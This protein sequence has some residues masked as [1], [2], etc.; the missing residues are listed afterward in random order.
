MSDNVMS[1]GFNGVDSDMSMLTIDE[2]NKR[3]RV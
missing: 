2:F 3:N 1:V